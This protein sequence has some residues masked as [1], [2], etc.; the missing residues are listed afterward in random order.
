[1]HSPDDTFA[2]RLAHRFH[3]FLAAEIPSLPD[4][5]IEQA[6]EEAQLSLFD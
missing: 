2:P 4:L 1:M 3:R 6:S 5:N